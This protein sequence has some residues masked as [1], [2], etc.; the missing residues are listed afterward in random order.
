MTTVDLTRLFAPESVAI[1]GASTT[2]GKIGAR[3]VDHLLAN[4]Y[5]GTIYPVNQRGGEVAGIRIFESVTAL[6]EAPDVAYV[7]VPA[8]AAVAATRQL[9]ERGTPYVIVSAAGFAESGTA[10][11]LRREQEL[12]DIAAA[13]GTRI[14]GPNCNG[15]Y[16]AHHRASIGFNTAHGLQHR[17]GGVAIL[18]HSGA[19]FSTIM[20]R[21][22]EQG[23]GLSAFVSVGNE[24][25]LTIVDYFE[26]FVA[27]ADTS[28]IAF[29]L[30]SLPDGVRFRAL[31]ERAHAAG[32]K[33]VALKLGMSDVGANAAVAHSSRLAGSAKAYESFLG[34]LGVG[35]VHTIEEFVGAATLA[36]ADPALPP[37]AT[38]GF[39]T[40]SGGA[41]TMVADAAVA[42]GIRVPSLSEATRA[43]IRQLAPHGLV[44]NP[45]DLG[46]AYGLIDTPTM[47]S[48]LAED[49]GVDVVIHY[50]HPMFSNQE[51]R[52]L[53]EQFTESARRSGKP[54]V[55]LAP[56]GVTRE[57]SDIYRAGGVIVFTDTNLAMRAI[58]A[59]SVAA[60][61]TDAKARVP[62]VALPA[63]Q[64]VLDDAASITVLAEAG[65]PMTAIATA[66]TAAEAV[67]RAQAIGKPVVLKGLV[68]GVAHKSDLGLV[69]V[70][71]T[72]D[73]D[74]DREAERLL[75]VG[76]HTVL[77]QP[78]AKGRVEAILGV[79]SEPGLGKFVVFGLGG[80]FAEAIHDITMVPTWASRE[81]FAEALDATRLGDVLL[82]SRWSAGSAREQFLTAAVA[83][84]RWG[85]AADAVEAVDINPVLIGEETVIGVDGLVILTTGQPVTV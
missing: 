68:D 58:A 1:I 52:V 63:A 41:G 3:V 69:V 78:M 2:P 77:I 20:L 45:I 44:E 64:G 22:K 74:I 48:L 75:G 23:M 60:P 70:G 73:E 57:E 30:D 35:L 27:D 54:H 82:S 43:R 50:Y 31:A 76:A 37:L 39:A 34:H 81:Q 47:F 33:L 9:A 15:I 72:K 38:V 42:A 21:A 66:T 12:R 83:L 40:M 53:A 4:G 13:T 55:L 6:P 17:P 25:D 46:G 18:S 49:V 5:A 65:V 26:H 67:D 62:A 19:L 61:E 11:G 51:R 79:V 84:A 80:V 32:K 59:A 24:S 36:D 71:L 29:I 28:C 7:L 14:I 10:D 56:G 16:S 85:E 8:D